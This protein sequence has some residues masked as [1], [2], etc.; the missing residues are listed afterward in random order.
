[1]VLETAGGHGRNPNGILG[2]L[3]REHFPGLVEYAGVTS[4][5]YTFVHYAVAPD[6]VDRDGRQFNNK[7]ERV[8]QELWVSLPRTILFN[9]SHLLHILEIMYGYIVFVCRISSGAMLDTRPGRMWCLRRAVR[10][11]SWTC[12]TRRASRPSSLTTAPSL[13][14]GEQE[15]RPNHVV[16]SGPVLAGK[17]KTLLLVLNMLIFFF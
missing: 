14:E 13:G 4:P 9:K 5:A 3:C 12:T 17:Y 6:A 2:L 11:S 16:D 8:K 1:M 10:S 15:G 7:V